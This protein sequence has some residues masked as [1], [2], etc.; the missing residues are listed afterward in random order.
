MTVADIITMK[1]AEILQDLPKY[2]TDTQSEHTVLFE[3]WY[4]QTWMMQG[5]TNF[6]FVRKHIIICEAQ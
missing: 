3:K 1:K 5:V 4:Q 6:Q 2:G